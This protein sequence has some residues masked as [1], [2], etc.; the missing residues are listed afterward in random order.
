MLLR[1]VIS[2]FLSFDSKVE[3]S[4][5]ATKENRHAHRLAS[6]PACSGKLLQAAAIWGGN[7]SGKSNFCKVFDFAQW[8]V[9]E[10]T[11]A[12]APISRR[13][14]RLRKTASDEPSRFEFELLVVVDGG[15]EKVFR[16]SFAVT[17]KAVIEERLAEVRPHSEKLYF[18]RVFKDGP[19]HE[20]NLEWWNRKG[21][22]PEAK[23]LAR[24][25]TKG[26]KPN[27]L[28]LHEAMDRNLTIL[29][30]VYRWFRDQLVVLQ[31]DDDFL[32]LAIEEPGRADLRSFTAN[33][34]HRM[35][36]GVVGVEAVEGPASTIGMPQQVQDSMLKS[37]PEGHEGIILRSPN[38][39]RFSVFRK[40]GELKSS[41][42]VTIR[43]SQDGKEIPFELSEESDGTRRLFDLAPAL[44]DVN[45]NTELR[46]VYVVDEID[47][48]MHTLMTRA[49]LEEYLA[50]CSP[51]RR[52]Q[53]IATTHDVLVMDQDLF[54]RDE[55]WFINIEDKSGETFMESLSDYQARHDKDVRKA[56][57][58]GKFSGIPHISQVR[59]RWPITAKEPDEVTN[60]LNED[61]VAYHTQSSTP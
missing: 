5:L 12:D 45:N 54:R 2:N 16:Y 51:D 50:T 42:I 32:S 35:G 40:D 14:F 34:L 19:E 21:V 23:L 15:E 13:P 53:M 10:G 55:M 25:V 4:M 6:T 61:T 59:R 7:A 37:M 33:L 56:Y 36:T 58:A 39:N 8:L 48:S 20:F 46:R 27:Q 38:G 60:R 29:A 57:L 44:H 52:C 1:L 49:V 28:F 47:R 43:H 30:P 31:P 26:T 17:G 11:R 18:E 41:R 3:F 9:V 22:D 24:L